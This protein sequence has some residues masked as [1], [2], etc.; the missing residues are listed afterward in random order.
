MRGVAAALLAVLL[1][2]TPALARDV[3]FTGAL[4]QG[5]LVVA[6]APGAQSATLDGRN[7]AVAVDGTFVFGLSPE[8]K[9]EARLVVRYGDGFEEAHTLPIKPQA[10]KVER[11]DGLPPAMVNPPP[12]VQARIARENTLI[13]NARPR[14]TP[15]IWFASGFAWPVVGR[16]SGVFGSR[17][18]LNGQPMSPHWGLDIAVP[19][20]TPV[21]A[22][23]PGRVTLAENDLYYTGGTIILDHGFGVTSTYA[24]LSKVGVK[25]GQ[26]VQSGEQIGAVGATG[27]VTGAHLHWTIHWQ[28]VRIDPALVV[29]PR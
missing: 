7:L 28:D 22:P 26:M 6:R 12:E 24:H 23:A 15:E 19:T 18:V 4:L 16:I 21:L 13:A 10:W 29:P 2:A 11:V 5:G 9:A 8:A 27:R 14:A 17:R 25:V 3:T 20:G 1:S